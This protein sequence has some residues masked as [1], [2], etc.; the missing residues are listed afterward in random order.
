MRIKSAS[1]KLKIQDVEFDIK[2]SNDGY[3]IEGY[4]S[5]FGTVDSYREVVERGAFLESIAARK[6]SGRKLPML[7]QHRTAEPIGVWDDMAEDPKGLF[8]RG[9]ILKGVQTAEEARIRAIAGA[10]TGLSIGYYVRD[11]SFDQVEG[12]TR[13]KRL[14][15]I[16]TSLVTF[17]ANDD[18]RVDAVKFQFANGGL[19]SMKDFEGFLRR[20]AGLSRSQAALVVTKGFAELVRRESATDDDVQALK[21]AVSELSGLNTELDAPLF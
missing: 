18:A 1:A 5:V 6:K 20:E 11:D 13:L 7:W 3:S 8:M 19:P 17:P 12:V 16:E 9:T 14:D 10:V 15:L 21:S 4:G 2:A